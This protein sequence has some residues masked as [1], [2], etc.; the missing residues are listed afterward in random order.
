MPA[1]LAFPAF[2]GEPILTLGSRRRHVDFESF[3]GRRLHDLHHGPRPTGGGQRGMAE[4]CWRSG[5][6]SE[7]GR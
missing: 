3:W 2:R 5:C 1:D 4:A 7:L 6:S